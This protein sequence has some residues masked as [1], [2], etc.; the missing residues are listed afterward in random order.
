M[1]VGAITVGVTDEMND[2]V[3]S[4]LPPKQGYYEWKNSQHQ[5]VKSDKQTLVRSESHV[6]D[7]KDTL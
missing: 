5:S 7:D 1:T 2:S 3:H 4:L 6:S